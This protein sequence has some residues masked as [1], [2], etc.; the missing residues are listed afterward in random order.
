MDAIVYTTNAG[1]TKRYAEMLSQIIK[2][3]IFS[4]AEAKKKLKK[5]S[6]VIYLGWVLADNIKN[7]NKARS[8]F[9]VKVIIAVGLNYEGK[10]KLEEKNNINNDTE[11]F[12]MIKGAFDREKLKGIYHFMVNTMLKFMLR[13]N[14]MSKLS[15]EEQKSLKAFANNSDFVSEDNLD[16]IVNYLDKN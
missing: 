7:L 16:E 12:F 8:L 9:D 10:E 3:P 13:P 6:A 1:S 14:Y 5:E 15:P 4:F 11:A 2:L